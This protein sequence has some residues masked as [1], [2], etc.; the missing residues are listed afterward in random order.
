MGGYKYQIKNSGLDSIG[1]G[2][3]LN[4]FV[5]VRN[6]KV[7]LLMKISLRQ[8]GIDWKGKNERQGD[9]LESSSISLAE[10]EC[11]LIKIDYGILVHFRVKI[12]I[13]LS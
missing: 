12:S 13:L 9:H 2:E 3:Q 7:P 8:Y 5:K 1:S 10:K 11:Q 4:I 6:M